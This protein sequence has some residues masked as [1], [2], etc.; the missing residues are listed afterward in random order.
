MRIAFDIWARAMLIYV[1]AM[2]PTLLCPIIF[3]YAV[4]LALVWGVAALMLFAPSVALAKRSGM[5][6]QGTGFVTTA[7]VGMTLCFAATY[8]ACY[9]M[10]ENNQDATEAM[11]ENIAYPLVAWV[12]AAI[13][14]ISYNRS[15][16]NYFT[17]K[18][19]AHA[20]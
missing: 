18:T 10:A 9:S 4:G 2:L 20:I 15:I 3:L 17:Q 1:V 13:S 8:M 11:T 19:I 14:L 12:S 6:E 5:F 7:M 16:R